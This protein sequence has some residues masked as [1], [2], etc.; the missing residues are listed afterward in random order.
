MNSQR[1]QAFNILD[2]IWNEDEKGNPLSCIPHPNKKIH[3]KNAKHK[4]GMMEKYPLIESKNNLSNAKQNDTNQ[5]K[6]FLIRQKKK[7]QKTK[8]EES[9][10]KLKEKNKKVSPDKEDRLKVLKK[11]NWTAYERHVYSESDAEKEDEGSNS[12]DEINEIN[13]KHAKTFLE[14]N[15]RDETD[16]VKNI[17]NNKSL[18]ETETKYTTTKSPA[19]GI[20]NNTESKKKK[21]Q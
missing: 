21:Y 6:K 12:E 17:S 10:E 7:E 3:I 1:K 2:E 16:F 20:I 19:V 13:D 14:K 11:L 15:A 4:S 8:E 18:H 9:K 5:N